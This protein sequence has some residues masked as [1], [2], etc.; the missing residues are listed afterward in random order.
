MRYTFVKLSPA[1][2][3]YYVFGRL[4]QIRMTTQASAS[5]SDT[6]KGI[7]ERIM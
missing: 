5:D 3:A 1:E 7:E 4:A 2:D 6:D